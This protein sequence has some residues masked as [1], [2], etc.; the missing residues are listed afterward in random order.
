[1]AFDM[2]MPE[3]ATTLGASL[4]AHRWAI[5][6]K[7]ARDQFFANCRAHGIDF[8]RGLADLAPHIPSTDLIALVLSAQ[9][10][11][12]PASL[13]ALDRLFELADRSTESQAELGVLMTEGRVEPLETQRPDS[14][15]RA[16]FD[17]RSPVF[18]MGV[19]PSVL[20]SPFLAKLKSASDPEAARLV[21]GLAVAVRCAHSLHGSDNFESEHGMRAAL[22]RD[23][24]V[25]L[26]LR[27][28]DS[29][30][31]ANALVRQVVVESWSQLTV[32]PCALADVHPSSAVQQAAKYEL[33]LLRRSIEDASPTNTEPFG[34]EAQNVM[35]WCV[36]VLYQHDSISGGLQS[37]ILLL[38]ALPV[39]AVAPDLRYWVVRADVKWNPE[40]DPLQGGGPYGLRPDDNYPDPPQPWCVIAKDM[41]AGIHAFAGREE[42][43]D[44]DL[45]SLR[46]DLAQ[47]CIDRLK[48][49]ERGGPSKEGD[50]NWRLGYIEAA[51]ALRINPRGRGHRTL[52]FIAESDPSPEVRVLAEKVHD[53]LR[54]G[55]RLHGHSARAACLRAIWYLFRAHIRSLHAPFDEAA[56]DATRDRMIRRTTEAMVGGLA[57]EISS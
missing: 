34:S 53:E 56:A 10:F 57:L 9:G 48:S 3:Q 52:H 18:W 32:G 29:P 54:G 35:Y 19:N 6:R 42:E 50:P 38:R 7:S 45:T 13:I 46:T 55:P 51:R 39:P 27:L 1:M 31:K 16:P 12:D 14:A 33:A 36:N 5:V 24:V 25:A 30:H 37:L 28:G 15:A 21:R 41:A 26:E 2:G 43:R 11:I 23:A 49:E 40:E 22:L 44:K 47:F 20:R 4:P 8:A 17:V